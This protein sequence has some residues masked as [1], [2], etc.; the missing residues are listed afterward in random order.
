M[1]LREAFAVAPGLIS[2]RFVV[3]RNDGRDVYGHPVM[4]C[5]AAANV[6]R[7]ALLGVRWDDAD[8]VDILNA[9]THEMLINQ[10]GRSKELAPIDLATEP[11]IAALVKTVDLEE[12]A[13]EG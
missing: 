13:A 6:A 9:V 1:T 5:L 3:L 12:L 4:P 2:A 8:A 10:R 11:D 7:E